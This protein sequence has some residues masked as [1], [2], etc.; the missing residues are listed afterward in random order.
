MPEQV[1]DLPACRRINRWSLG[2][3]CRAASMELGR[4]GLMLSR[5]ENLLQ[6]EMG[7]R[8]GLI[9]LYLKCDLLWNV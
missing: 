2:F 9:Q 6:G 1:K 8:L 3:P 7:C 4:D 5:L